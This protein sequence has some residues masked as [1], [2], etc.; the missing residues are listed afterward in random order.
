MRRLRNS[1]APEP[2]DTALDGFDR[3]E[4]EG[5]AIAP[6]ADEL[7]WLR[8]FGAAIPGIPLASGAVAEAGSPGPLEQARALAARGRRLD[9]V[10]LLRRQLEDHPADAAL[11]TELA[12][13]LEQDGDAAGALRELDQALAHAADPVPVLVQRGALATRAGRPADAEQDLR[14]AIRRAP[15]HGPAWLQLGITLLRLGRAADAAETLR[16]AQRLAPAD[17]EAVYQL[18]E[19]VQAQGDLAG[20]LQLL[21]QA[22][23]LAPADPRSYKL[24]GRLLDRLGRTDEALAMHRRA[25]EAGI[26]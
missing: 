13:L 26:R 5:D 18:G 25:R 10:L 9:A 6:A 3:L 2:D 4:L 11:H 20:A 1:R 7:P 15:E 19:A 23:G 21:E 16:A 17:A 14:D 24:M 22:A 12:G 8:P